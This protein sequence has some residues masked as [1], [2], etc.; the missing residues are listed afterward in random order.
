MRVFYDGDSNPVLGGPRIIDQIVRACSCR[1]NMMLLT[2]TQYVTVVGGL[3]KLIS[4]AKRF[5]AP[6]S[7]AEEVSVSESIKQ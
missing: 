3:A 7:A 6:T 4:P 5:N 1:C 2:K